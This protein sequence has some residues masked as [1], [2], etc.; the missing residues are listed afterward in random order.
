MQLLVPLSDKTH[1][2]KKILPIGNSTITVRIF[3]SYKGIKDTNLVCYIRPTPI[4]GE[5]MN[6]EN[7]KQYSN[8]GLFS[9]DSGH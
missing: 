9:K 8:N 7:S 4:K 6:V 3:K 5:S 2:C 1:F